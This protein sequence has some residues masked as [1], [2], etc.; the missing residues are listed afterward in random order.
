MTNTGQ[1]T[2]TGREQQSAPAGSAHGPGRGVYKALGAAAIVVV[3]LFALVSSGF[4]ST[5]KKAASVQGP[6]SVAVT[7]TS[8]TSNSVIASDQVTVR[9][10]V[11]PSDAVVQIQ[12]RPAVVGDGVFT[13]TATLHGGKTTIDVVG[14]APSAAPSATSVVIDRQSSGNSGGTVRVI[15]AAPATASD[16]ATS[17]A[18][19]TSCGGDLAV[20]PNTTCAFAEDV[21]SAY[22]GSGP[23]TVVAYSP[24]TNRTYA[25]SCSAGSYA[26]C[27]GGDNAAVYFPSQSAGVGYQGPRP[28][29]SYPTA[30][31]VQSGETSC[32]GELSVGPNTTC[33]FAEE[34]RSA[35]GDHGPGTVMAFSPATD[36]TYAMSCTDASDVVC[37]GG[38]DASV[39]FP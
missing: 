26:V 12:G 34:V 2:Q 6:G 24:V 15:Q 11:S 27:T 9:G 29:Y 19:Q 5:G 32:G 22:A 8:P 4:G 37:T 30:A 13:G 25:M 39:Y 33:A 35:Y 16:G 17:Y 20:G 3:V 28:S 1:Y 7:V 31:A 18:G 38:N 14:S 10:T 23:G 21:R 36:R